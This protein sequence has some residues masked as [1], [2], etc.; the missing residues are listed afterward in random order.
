[1]CPRVALLPRVLWFVARA[2]RTIMT[3]L[4]DQLRIRKA[5]QFALLRT[6]YERGNTAP[7]DPTPLAEQLSIEPAQAQRALRYS[8]EE[9][10]VARDP[11][12]SELVVLTPYGSAVIE[13]ALAHPT[14]ATEH[15]PAASTLDLPAPAQSPASAAATGD[16]RAA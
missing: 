9:G 11:T 10:L 8:E 13:T 4:V 2:P 6:L 3:T 5:Q 1:M 14:E 15:F 12:Q 7:I 16:V